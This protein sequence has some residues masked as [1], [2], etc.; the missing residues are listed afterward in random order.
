MAVI[1]DGVDTEADAKEPHA[2]NHED[3]PFFRNDE[4]AEVSISSKNQL[5]V[6]Q[7]SKLSERMSGIQG[8]DGPGT[9]PPAEGSKETHSTQTEPGIYAA[10]QTS[11]SIDGTDEDHSMSPIIVKD[12]DATAAAESEALKKLKAQI[13]E[14]SVQVTSLNGKLVQSY[15]RVGGLE[16]DLERKKQEQ[17]DLQGKVVK[18]EEQRK[19][20]EDKYQGGL[21]VEK[22]SQYMPLS[23][24]PHQTG[25]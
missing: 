7:D 2:S 5:D 13:A 17:G 1:E 9:G 8:I 11:A 21:L 12:L 14:L 3:D 16:D 19:E 24:S 23:V 20:W 18:L 6:I 15:N 10:T 25:H 4:D 22:V